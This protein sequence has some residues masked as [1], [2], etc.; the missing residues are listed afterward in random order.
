MSDLLGIGTLVGAG[1]SFAGGMFTNAQN[2]TNQREQ[3]D[4]EERM[5]NTAHQREVADLRAAGLNPILSATGGKGAVTPSVQPAHVD[6]PL[7]ETGALFSAAEQTRLSSKRLE[8]EQTLNAA[9]LLDIGANIKLKEAQ[10][11][12]AKTRGNVNEVDATSKSMLNANPDYVAQ[13]IRNL[14]QA[15]RVGRSQEKANY[16]SAKASEWSAQ[17]KSLPD[18]AAKI[19]GST[20]R[21]MTGKDAPSLMD[22]FRSLILPSGQS[23][24]LTTKPPSGA[25]HSAKH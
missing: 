16:S 24:G 18:L 2:T 12:D 1:L 14:H 25:R 11:Y 9:Q 22:L 4:W 5:A 20:F 23:T 7:K 10:A 15:E 6:N 19:L 17:G 13:T 8:L 3:R 21:D